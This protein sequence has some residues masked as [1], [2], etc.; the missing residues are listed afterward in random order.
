MSIEKI[1]AQLLT[2]L[3]EYLQQNWILSFYPG[4]IHSRT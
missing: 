2:V 1:V 4:K 3:P